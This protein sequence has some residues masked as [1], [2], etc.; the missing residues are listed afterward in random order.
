MSGFTPNQSVTDNDII[1]KRAIDILDKIL[2]HSDI[3][4][5]FTISDKIANVD[6]K[7]ELMTDRR[8]FGN[9]T[10]QI[11]TYPTKYYGQSK[12]DFP[13]SIFGYAQRCSNE[14]VF[15]FAVNRKEKIAYWK[16]IDKSLIAKYEDKSSQKKVTIHFEENEIVHRGNI[17]EIVKRWK[18]LHKKTCNLIIQTE[19]ISQE[20]VQLKVQLEKYQN[21]TFT[22]GRGNIIKLQRFIDEYNYLLDYEYNYIKHHYYSNAW[23]IGIVVF[24]YGLKELSYIIHK[25]ESGEN[26]LLIKEIPVDR[27]KYFTNYSVMSRNCRENAINDNPEKYALKLI[28]ERV[29]E[30]LEYKSVLFLTEETATEYIFDFLRTECNHI[31]IKQQESY[32]LIPLKAII[33]NKYPRIS[34]KIPCVSM[35]GNRCININNLYESIQFLINKGNTNINMLYPAIDQHVKTGFVS[36]WYTPDQALKKVKFVY[37]LLPSLFD[38]YMITVFPYLKDRILLFS[39]YDII[40]VN[41]IYFDGVADEYNQNHQIVLNYLDLSNKMNVLPDLIISL[42]YDSDIYREN[43]ISNI[44]SMNKYFF[45]DK[46]ILYNGGKYKVMKQE[47]VNITLF[48]SNYCIHNILYKY[49]GDRFKDYFEVINR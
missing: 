27:V 38:A 1:E 12:Y 44:N 7:I 16:Y 22:I 25:I 4:T 31:N 45:T 2:S 21:P 29:K 17:D 41:L 46:P 26:G 6:G 13:T 39:G 24:E 10:V 28:Q 36:D 47:R 9:I 15:L 32:E 11:K 35:N 33:E 23:K 34:A 18:E 42:N 37:E 40:L 30:L 19:E 20:N 3:K 14:V 49:L 48:F 8:I 43:E 5:H